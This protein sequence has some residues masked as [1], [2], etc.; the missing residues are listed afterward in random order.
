[1][2]KRILSLALYETATGKEIAGRL[3]FSDTADVNVQKM[4]SLGGKGK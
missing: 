4:A 3:T 2:R 1:M